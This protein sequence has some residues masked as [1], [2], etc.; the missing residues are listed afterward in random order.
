VQ[1]IWKD[2]VFDN[3][4]RQPTDLLKILADGEGL[5]GSI[6]LIVSRWWRRVN[7]CRRD[8]QRTVESFGMSSKTFSIV[9]IGA[10][11][12]IIFTS[13]IVLHF[14]VAVIRATGTAAVIVF[15]LALA[16]VI[17]TRG[18]VTATRGGRSTT[19]TRR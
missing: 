9:T 4:R 10:V 12:A 19:A 16:A 14:S 5:F 17:L 6:E 11:L 3:L 7:S 1:L 15:A 8:Q 13:T 2:I 18:V